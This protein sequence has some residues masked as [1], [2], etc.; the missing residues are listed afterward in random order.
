[1]ALKNACTS[2]KLVN[3]IEITPC[4]AVEQIQIFVAHCGIA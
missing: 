4:L 3:A 2:L 1:M